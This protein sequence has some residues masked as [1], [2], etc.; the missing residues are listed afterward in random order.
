MLRVEGFDQIFYEAH[1]DFSYNGFTQLVGF[2]AFNIQ[3]CTMH[4]I[5]SQFIE[6]CVGKSIHAGGQVPTTI[7]ASIHHPK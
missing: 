1:G 3:E 5:V 6:D 2:T 4:S 7:F